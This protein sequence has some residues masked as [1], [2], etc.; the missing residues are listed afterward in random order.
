[1]EVS[2]GVLR[3]VVCRVHVWNRD[4]ERVYRCAQLGLVPSLLKT[5]RDPSDDEP[6]P[7]V[8]TKHCVG[9]KGLYNLGNTC[10]MNSVLQPLFHIPDLAKYFLSFATGK[11][12][13]GHRKSNCKAADQPCVA[14]ELDALFVRMYNGNKKPV[15]PSEMLYA[16]WKGSAQMAGY[17]QQDAHEFFVCLRSALHKA[18][19]GHQFNCNCIVHELFAGVLQSD[20]TCPHCHHKAE[21]YDPFLDLSLDIVH[22]GQYMTSLT[23]CLEHFTRPEPIAMDAY[24]CPQ[25]GLGT[26][27][28]HKRMLMRATPKVLVVHLKRFEHG[29]SRHKIDKPV[30]FPLFLDLQPYTVEYNEDP[31]GMHDFESAGRLP[32]YKLMSVVAHVGSL[33][34]GHY[35][36]YVRFRDDWFFIDDAQVT[37]TTEEAVLAAPAYMLFYTALSHHTP[38]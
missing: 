26:E 21:T 38:S 9:V 24:K 7:A 8:F 28:L 5:V 31:N 34:S 25:C 29:H 17:E 18:I 19:D 30:A 20:L 22:H 11:G 1:M 15:C 3:C 27:E 4:L 16:V 35:T 23:E 14:C 13:G 12:A 10:F 33:D 6:N 36:S 2:T 32:P 37:L